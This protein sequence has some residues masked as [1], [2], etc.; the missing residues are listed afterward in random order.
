MVEQKRVENS[1]N[2]SILFHGFFPSLPIFPLVNHSPF[3][4]SRSSREE[5]LSN[6]G[7]ARGKLSSRAI[8]KNRSIPFRRLCL[9]LVSS[10]VFTPRRANESSVRISRRGWPG[11]VELG[12]KRVPCRRILVSA[13]HISTSIRIKRRRSSSVIRVVNGRT[14]RERGKGLSSQDSA[15]NTKLD[16]LCRSECGTMLDN[17]EGGGGGSLLG[18]ISFVI[19]TMMHVQHVRMCSA[20]LRNRFVLWVRVERKYTSF[21]FLNSASS[22][23]LKW[24]L[25]RSS[26]SFV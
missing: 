22:S 2:F 26:H 18:S 13:I 12:L 14:G 19:E 1:S 24:H 9:L 5:C 17:R 25:S 8:C 6:D 11:R 15:T 21:F 20:D 10:L 7:L 16:T 23:W 4:P 3:L